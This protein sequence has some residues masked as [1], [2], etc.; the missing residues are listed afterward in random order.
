MA[1]KS[2]AQV[3]WAFWTSIFPVF[4]D[5]AP[6]ERYIISPPLNLSSATQEKSV[7]NHSVVDCLFAITQ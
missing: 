5:I 1:V 7:P 6:T 4:T 3:G 2:I